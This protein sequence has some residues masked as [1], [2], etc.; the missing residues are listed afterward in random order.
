MG[1]TNITLG[2]AQ[3]R[4]TLGAV[5]LIKDGNDGTEINDF[6]G[7]SSS[8]VVDGIIH[9]DIAGRPQSGTKN[10]PYVLGPLAS[11]ISYGDQS[12]P[13]IKAGID[14]NGVDGVLEFPNG[15]R[16]PVQVVSV[17]VDETYWQAVGSGRAYFDG[18]G[19]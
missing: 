11:V 14:A 16:L 4:L 12:S 7:S 19:R 17:P 6:R 8:K 1:D 2:S 13:Q 5:A 3:M 10:E 15:A 18:D 9:I